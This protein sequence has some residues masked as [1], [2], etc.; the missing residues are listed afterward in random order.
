MTK[1]KRKTDLRSR[2]ANLPEPIA[3]SK[4]FLLWRHEFNKKRGV[5]VK[6]PF[7]TSGSK[8]Y[9][10]GVLGT[11]KDLKRLATLD[12]ALTEY[13]ANPE[14]YDGVG[15]ALIGEGVGAFDIDKCLEDGD[16][17]PGHAGAY[18]VEKAEKDGAYIEI[19]PSG[20]GLRILGKSKDPTAYSKDQL[21]YWGTERYVTLTGSLWANP[22]GWKNLT[23]LR[24]T[25]PTRET[26]P[27]TDDEEES[28]VTKRVIEELQSALSSMDADERE[29]WVKMGHALKTL[30][31]RGKELWLEWSSKSD[32]YNEKD[33]EYTWESFRPN[34]TSHRTVFAEAQRNWEWENPRST[35]TEDDPDGPEDEE[36]TDD[37]NLLDYAIELGKPKLYPTEFVLDGFLPVGVSLIAGAW[38]AGKSTNLIPLFA[39]VAH[40]APDEWGFTPAL[41]RHVVWVTEAPD[42][43]R[44]TI[45]SMTKDKGTAPWKKFK[46]WFHMIPAHREKP[47]ALAAIVKR[48]VAELTY[49]LPDNGF[50]VRPVVVL[51]TV[52]ANI[53][54]ENESDNSEVGSAM[55]ELKEALPGVSLVLVGHTP[56]AL[57]RG[58]VSEMTFRGA[59]AWEADAVATYFLV[60]DPETSMRFLALGKARFAPDYKEI[61]FGQSEG[62][63][64]VK[65]EWGEP[66]SKAFLHGVPQKSSGEQRRAEQDRV[67]EE[68]K[69]ER[70]SGMVSERQQQA[71]E[72]L[73]RMWEEAS[74]WPTTGEVCKRLDGK[75]ALKIGAIDQLISSEKIKE[76]TIPTKYKRSPR[77]NKVLVL[78]DMD[79]ELLFEKF[80][81]R[82]KVELHDDE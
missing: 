55:S 44:D 9:G 14:F 71:L 42:Q 43:A 39:S 50:A 5:L 10:K 72:I 48:T 75:A 74:E 19:S 54:L 31:N 56:K 51:D 78:A 46:K 16:M 70:E 8:R 17:I 32:K 38:G 27:K 49:T 13:E 1:N 24:S 29:L 23:E 4:R 41:R 67:K 80:A 61:S 6:T 15:L 11:G 22:K 40:L 58:D 28:L 47:K 68:Q 65:T 60:H 66:Q 21:E 3:G 81:D 33:A 62:R 18:V 59:G 25:L 45:Y 26:K 77:I 36:E 7:Y 53:D 64:L 20:K 73:G 79:E 2:L 34:H 30:G 12:D 57:V 82:N 69:E 63:E 52:S 76:V 37:D 35:R